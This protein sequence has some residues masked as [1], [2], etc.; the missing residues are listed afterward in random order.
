M[1]LAKEPKEIDFLIKSNPWP[2]KDLADFRQ[3]MQEIKYKNKIKKD[4]A[5]KN[6]QKPKP[7]AKTPKPIKG[8]I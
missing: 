7:P 4:S 8:G 5:L 3:L 6:P 2:E 1:K